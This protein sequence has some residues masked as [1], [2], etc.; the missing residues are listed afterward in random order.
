LVVVGQ[1]FVGNLGGLFGGDLFGIDKLFD[2]GSLFNIGDIFGGFDFSKFKNLLNI[3][4]LGDAFEIPG[5]GKDIDLPLLG[6]G[7]FLPDFGKAIDLPDLGGKF[8]IP[9]LKGLQIPDLKDLVLPK[10]DD[11]GKFDFDFGNLC[12]TV[13]VPPVVDGSAPIVPPVVTQPEPAE[14]IK[15]DLGFDISDIF[16]FLGDIDFS[17]ISDLNGGIVQNGQDGQDGQD[18]QPGQVVVGKGP[19]AIDLGFNFDFGGVKKATPVISLVDYKGYTPYVYDCKGCG[20]YFRVAGIEDTH[21][22]INVDYEQDGR[23]TRITRR[24]ADIEEAESNCAYTELAYTPQVNNIAESTALVSTSNLYNGVGLE[25]KESTSDV[26]NP[27]TVT[28]NGAALLSQL[29]SCTKYDI[30]NAYSCDNGK[31][32]SNIVTFETA[33]CE[34]MC[35]ATSVEVRQIGLFGSGMVLSWDIVPG[36]TYQL[37]YKTEKENEWTKYKTQTPFVIL[38]GLDMCTVY[39]F[40]VNIICETDLVSNESNMLSVETG[41]CKFNSDLMESEALAV[42]PTIAQNYID[43]VLNDAENISELNIYNLAGNLVKTLNPLETTISVR[44]LSSGT[45]VVTAI[46]ADSVLTTRFMKQ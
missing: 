23:R 45:Y 10:L 11:F 35:E 38:F 19:G 20:K 25:I 9:D 6:D 5:F 46:H 44:D 4:L 27:V 43:I 18:G 22:F 42:Y 16:G 39:E 13:E 21:E 2:F 17:K 33:G 29:K 32:E 1:S 40:S 15:F 3:D 8:N 26:W 36:Y 30:R 24:I 14:D 28:T 31:I 12:G 37:N 7:I 34:N 41:N